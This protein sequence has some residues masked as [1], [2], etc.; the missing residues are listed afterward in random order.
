M[1]WDLEACNV[2]TEIEQGRPLVLVI[3]D[4]QNVLD[5]VAAV[6]SE[7]GFGCRCC[8]SENEAA[9]AIAD[10]APELIICDLNLHGEN[11]WEACQRIRNRP[12]MAGVPVMF[13][14]GAQLPDVIRRSY[15]AG[16]GNYCLRKPFS[17]RVLLELIDQA[18]GVPG[19]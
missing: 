10:A 7:A 17:P 6:L 1:L 11:G 4:Q 5:N 8:A 9:T 12:G 13:L 2:T 19:A 3:D 18:L 15:S 14:S 16:S